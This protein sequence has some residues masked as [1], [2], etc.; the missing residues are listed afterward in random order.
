MSNRV[1]SS[2]QKQRI[3]LQSLSSIRFSFILDKTPKIPNT[4]QLNFNPEHTQTKY[5]QKPFKK[6]K[7]LTSTLSRFWPS[8]NFLF[9][10]SRS[11]SIRLLRLLQK[12]LSEAGLLCGEVP[13]KPVGSCNQN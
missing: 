9:R 7:T 6:L 8:D 5:T 4:H 13:M 10:S 1:K 2:Q 3:L 11:E 12:R